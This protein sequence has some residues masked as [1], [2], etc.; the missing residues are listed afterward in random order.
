MVEPP[1]LDVDVA[2]AGGLQGEE[3]DREVLAER[4]VGGQLV[5]ATVGVEVGLLHALEGER[6][7]FAGEQA[8]AQVVPALPVDECARRVPELE[9]AGP[10]GLPRDLQGQLVAP[11]MQACR[12]LLQIEV[13]LVRSELVANEVVYLGGMLGLAL[14]VVQLPQCDV[15][16]ALYCQQLP[17]D[18]LDLQ[19]E[20]LQLVAPLLF[21]RS[22]PPWVSRRLAVV[23]ANSAA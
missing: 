17:L 5:L 8:L 11:R 2:S 15:A 10:L 16:A 7:A 19:A 12:L 3:L 14:V 20:D 1:L 18:L 4:D 22:N 13:E 9:V 6:Q 21:R 23:P